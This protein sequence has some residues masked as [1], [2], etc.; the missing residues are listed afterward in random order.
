MKKT[1]TLI[2]LA[3]AFLAACNNSDKHEPG[4]GD[5]APG[6]TNA[7]REL[8]QR[9]QETFQ[10]LPAIASNAQNPITDAKVLLGQ[11]L[12]Y[13]TRLSKTGNNSCN[14]C[15]NLATFG[16]DNLPTS[17]GD[18]GGFGGR[19]S[20]TVLN[21]ALHTFQFWDGRAKDVEEQAG[22]PILNPVEMAIPSK[23]FLIA[24]LK[25]IPAYRDMFKSAFPAASDAVTYDNVQNAIA[26]FE[27]TLITPSAFDKYLSG[28]H[29][30]LTPEQ[31][32]GMKTFMDVGCIQCHS[33]SNLGGAM[34]Q[35][36]G[37]FADYRDWTHSKTNDQGK[38]DLTKL[39]A[40]K[41]VFKVPGLRNIAKTHPYFHDGS[42]ADL[43]EAVKIMGKVQLNKDLSEAQ[44]QG[45]VDFLG[46]LTGEVPAE[47]KKVPE[48]LA[49]K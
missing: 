10:P 41:D 33:G 19:N 1:A 18:N 22:G 42:V 47:A 30:A 7:D 11:H 37:V 14:S 34:F 15:H 49:S 44:V 13:D 20:P 16:V 24:K 9:A 2:L 4:K 17:K 39:S 31:R 35:K 8:L 46:A 43:K 25:D 28:D 48:M 45:I 5:P 21:A 6:I 36:F 29:K 23:D 26:A 3:V 40:D 38:L 27:R 32:I 12:Y